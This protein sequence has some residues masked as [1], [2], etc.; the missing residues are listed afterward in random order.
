MY[1]NFVSMI[2]DLTE[3]AK[4]LQGKRG[5]LTPFPLR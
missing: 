1:L 5:K 2:I 4:G 3:G